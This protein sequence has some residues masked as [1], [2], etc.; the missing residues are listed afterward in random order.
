M[1]KNLKH[2]NKPTEKFTPDLKNFETSL[3]YEGMELKAHKSRSIKDLKQQ[4][5]R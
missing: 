1:D 2:S 3:S 5:A 4:Y